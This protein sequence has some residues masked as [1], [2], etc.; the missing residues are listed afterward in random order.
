MTHTHVL[1]LAAGKGTRMKSALPKVLHGMAGRPMLGYVLDAASS[2]R[3][4]LV[5]LVVGHRGDD[6]A[7]LVKSEAHVRCVTQ[8]P[9]L[10]T[11][12]AVLQAEGALRDATG[13]LILLSGDV[14]L[15]SPR[16]LDALLS[17]HAADGAAVTSLTASVD[18]PA[19]DLRIVRDQGGAIA[20]IVEERDASVA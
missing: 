18:R 7:A 5:T 20:R 4:E 13:T 1:V 17:A 16:T 15:L 8:E 9:Q 12:H 3:P 19:G 6:V 10:G 2:L 14:P 11:A